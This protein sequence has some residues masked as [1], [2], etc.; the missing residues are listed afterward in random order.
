MISCVIPGVG[1]RDLCSLSLS[2]FVSPEAPSPKVHCLPGT[3]PMALGL[4]GDSVVLISE[5]G[6]EATQGP[7]EWKGTEICQAPSTAEG[8]LILKERYRRPIS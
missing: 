7:Q 2:S 6:L 4:E 8:S 5:W 3:M 1:G